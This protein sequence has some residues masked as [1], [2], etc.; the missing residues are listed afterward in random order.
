MSLA[1]APAPS[2]RLD[3]VGAEEFA[4]LMDR[5]A[6]WEAAPHLAIALSGGGDSFALA[7][8]ARDWARARGGRVTALTVDHGLRPESAAEAQEVGARCTALGIEQ[9]ILCW[10][11]ERPRSGVQAAARAA[12][13]R[14]LE[15]WCATH[16][17]LHLLLGHQRE[18]QAETTLMRLERHSGVA[19]LAGMAACV[20]RRAVRL[21]RPLLSVSR[22][23]L[24][25]TLCFA[26][27]RWIDDPSNANPAF[28]RARLRAA[29][30][31]SGDDAAIE[32]LLSIAGQAAAARRTLEGKTAALLGQAAAIDPAGLVW[33][34]PEPI[35]TA[36]E[37]VARMALAAVIAT[38]SGTDYPPRLDRLARLSQALP[39]AG[40]R[41]LGGCLIAPR[42]GKL[43]VC[44][45]PAAVAR[46]VVL[47]AGR[48][49]RWDGRF[50]ATLATAGGVDLTLGA[51]GADA[52]RLTKAMPAARLAAIPPIARPAL[53]ALR[54][55]KD[56][57]AVPAL[58]Y[59]SRMWEGGPGVPYVVFRPTR[60]LTSA[61]FTIV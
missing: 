34:D 38:V 60:P 4:H 55:G 41:T 32:R 37:P 6:P 1:H 15:E 46:P 31:A 50:T 8:L 5:F 61:G 54:R 11:G 9:H 40:T 47:A 33:L 35:R 44:R 19:G 26:G 36:P 48:Q 22:A 58:G 53:A 2:G 42:R 24:E 13:Y 14:L 28:T 49:A 25:A 27:A 52:A 3:P 20:E 39:L 45:E 57:V 51:L 29:L 23:R 16:G 7:L 30:A 56:V 59:F 18:D 10:T 12:R 43:L 21:V 17:V